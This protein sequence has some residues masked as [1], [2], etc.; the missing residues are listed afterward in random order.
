MET[1]DELS[2]LYEV[3]EEL[4]KSS[5]KDTAKL[6]IFLDAAKHGTKQERLCAIQMLFRHFHSFFTRKE[7]QSKNEELQKQI[8]S[9][10]GEKDS[11]IRKLV[12][13]SLPIICKNGKYIIPVV[14]VLA[15]VL[16]WKDSTE[17]NLA[18]ASLQSLMEINGEQTIC[19][20][21]NAAQHD[22]P[23]RERMSIL[24]FFEDKT[25]GNYTFTEKIKNQ[26]TELYV[27]M[28]DDVS[29]KE[30]SE[31]LKLINK[32]Q[33][34]N[35]PRCLEA[36]DSALENDNFST[37]EL[38]HL[39]CDKIHQTPRKSRAA[40]KKPLLNI[41]TKLFK[42]STLGA[43]FI[44]EF[45][46]SKMDLRRVEVISIA[47]RVIQSI[48]L[49]EIF[50]D[51]MDE[52]LDQLDRLAV[53]HTLTNAETEEH[54]ES[55]KN[56]VN[57]MLRDCLDL[58]DEMNKEQ[59]RIFFKALA[60]LS[61]GQD[62]VK[63]SNEKFVAAVFDKIW[64]HCPDIDD[65]K[66]NASTG[67]GQANLNLMDT[68]PAMFVMHN[69]VENVPETYS[70]IER[71]EKHWRER[72]DLLVQTIGTTTNQL[73]ESLKKSYNEDTNK[74]LFVGNQVGLMAFI[75]LGNQI[76]KPKLVPSW[77]TNGNY[78]LHN[79]AALQPC[80]SSSLNNELSEKRYN[81]PRGKRKRSRS[82]S[83]EEFM[84]EDFEDEEESMSRTTSWAS[85]AAVNGD[86]DET[87][88][89]SRRKTK[90][91]SSVL[92]SAA[93]QKIAW[94]IQNGELDFVKEQLKGK[95]NEEILNGRKAIHIASD[96]GQL[97]IVKF[98]VENGAAVDEADKYGLTP[99]VTAVWEN[100][101]DI[102]QYL[103]S[104][105]ANKAQ[106]APDGT[107]LSKCTEDPE[108]QALVA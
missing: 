41:M 81:N 1:D 30:S 7:D 86:M 55:R 6:E 36:L 25:K 33:F 85:N 100:H 104:K 79:E 35:F 3:C 67:Q 89:T 22:C 56:T 72:M 75:F 59:Q 101:K 44:S 32:S 19:A 2:R 13:K 52:M 46:V 12:I 16:P 50:L 73:K 91:M 15:Q 54:Q 63:T 37:Q 97:D 8:Y 42:S 105:G 62:Y 28:I 20:M 71:K 106:K 99:L 31:L 9:F 17:V 18:K 65:F 34:T 49:D 95:V 60:T 66:I 103:I 78:L 53:A 51:D 24:S 80:S 40:L 70:I 14:E 77:L 27:K 98:C 68:E 57:F 21:F 39:I 108:I 23:V 93:A 84:D 107:E 29:N 96:Y 58:L 88:D 64:T 76:K 48:P 102:V 69:L 26:N 38:L 92:E 83:T 5:I 45:V 74:T 94:A 61:H 87:E 10:L 4:D 82:K 43:K 47:E 90:E 11:D